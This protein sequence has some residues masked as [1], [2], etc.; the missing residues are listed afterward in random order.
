MNKIRIPFIE[1]G[2]QSECGLCCLAMIMSYYKCCYEIYELRSEYSIGRDGTNL[3]M[4]KRVA[5]EKGFKCKGFRINTIDDIMVPAILNENNE[6]FIVAEKRIKNSIVILDPQRGRYRL[7]NED[8]KERNIYIGLKITKTKQVKERK[9]RKIFSAYKGLL[10]NSTYILIGVFLLTI[11]LQ[12]L[13]LVS[14][15]SAN[16]FVDLYIS[17]RTFI[18]VKILLLFVLILMLIH[19]SLGSIKAI[20]TV[21]LQRLFNENLAKSFAD[22]ILYLPN[23]FFKKRGAGDIVHRYSGTVIVREMLSSRI[24]EIWL[25]IGL[26]FVYNIYT[27]VLSPLFA[28]IMDI[29][30]IIIIIISIFNVVKGQEYIAKEVME[31]ARTS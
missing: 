25:D 23:S 11:I 4:L 21:R 30:A 6:H 1:Q 13:A 27:F 7:S 29:I 3:L 12:M 5:E 28:I 2:E 17:N 22:K 31:E 18:D 16:Y 10:K 26:V 19:F 24:I 14:P 15:I 20:L 8:I 9:R